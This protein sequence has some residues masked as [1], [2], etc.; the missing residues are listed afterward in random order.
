MARHSSTL[1]WRNPWRVEP[2]RLQSMGSQRV[3]HDWVTSLTS[4]T[5]GPTE[6]TDIL[7]YKCSYLLNWGFTEP[8]F[9]RI[10]GGSTGPKNI[11]FTSGKNKNSQIK[12]WS[13]CGC[14]E[15]C[16]RRPLMMPC[17][18]IWA[19]LVCLLLT[20]ARR[21]I[22]G[23]SVVKN[24]PTNAGDMSSILRLGRSP[25]EGNGNLLQYSCLENPTDRGSWWATVH[26]DTK[27]SDMT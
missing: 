24:P 25:G 16:L 9:N 4:L 26:G 15:G 8:W 14:V 2:G 6:K 7:I 27:D 12:T 1:A 11:I 17:L 22:P 5:H 21:G 20:N 10:H 19:G 13:K 23:S 3:R 18:W